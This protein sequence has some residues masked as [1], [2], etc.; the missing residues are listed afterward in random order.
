MRKYKIDSETIVNCWLGYSTTKLDG[1]APKLEDLAG[2]DREFLAKEKFTNA[3]KEEPLSDSP[4]IHNI[5]TIN[6]LY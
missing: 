5:T 3:V 1:A 2:F 4:V 6:Q